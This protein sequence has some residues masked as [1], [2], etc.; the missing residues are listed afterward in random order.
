MLPLTFTAKSLD[1]LRRWEE[2]HL[3]AAFLAFAYAIVF[4]YNDLHCSYLRVERNSKHQ[5]S[6]FVL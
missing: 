4:R 2:P 3:T 6:S 5:S 1:K